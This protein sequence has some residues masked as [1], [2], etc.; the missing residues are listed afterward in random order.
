MVTCRSCGKSVGGSA[1]TC[2]HCGEQWPARSRGSMNAEMIVK[3]FVV[4]I[5][6]LLVFGLALSL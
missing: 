2:P 3:V 1:S 6:A 4:V 5:F